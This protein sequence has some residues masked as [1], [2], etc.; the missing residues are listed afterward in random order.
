VKVITTAA[1]LLLYAMGGTAPAADLERGS[2]PEVSRAGAASR[3]DSLDRLELGGTNEH[4]ADSVGVL[5][6]AGELQH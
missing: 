4:G 1:A 5:H 3:L 2:G 6:Q